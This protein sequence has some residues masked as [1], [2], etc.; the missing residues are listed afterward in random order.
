M[1]P[2]VTGAIIAVV[3]AIKKLGIPRV[4][5]IVVIIVAAVLGVLY[6]A[7]QDADLVNGAL[8]GLL[9]S[10]IITVAGKVSSK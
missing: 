9:A 6:A 10:G 3:E 1:D 5:G 4:E 8:N 2:L 7:Y